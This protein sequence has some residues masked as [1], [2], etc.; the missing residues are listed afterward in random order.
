MIIYSPTHGKMTFEGMID[1]I[2]Q[3]MNAN[4]YEYKIIIGTDSS[5]RKN[6][7]V[8]IVTAIVIQRLGKG[9]IYFWQKQ[10]FNKIFGLRT[11]IYQE[12]M[13]SLDMARRI[14]EQGEIPLILDDLEI[15]VDI[16]TNGETRAMIKEIVGMVTGNGFPVKTKP[17]AYVASK[18]ADRHT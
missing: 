12:A 4:N 16:G 17:D 14:I 11:R 2:I 7:E 8:E 3:Y 9:G 18:V 1:R 10:K 5:P 6:G 15:H 13:T